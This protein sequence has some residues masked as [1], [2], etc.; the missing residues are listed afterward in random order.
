MKRLAQDSDEIA[1][2]LNFADRA[3]G[4]IFDHA[5]ALSFRLYQFPRDPDA[6]AVDAVGLVDEDRTDVSASAAAELARLPPCSPRKPLGLPA[7]LLC[8]RRLVVSE[9]E[10]VAVDVSSVA[11]LCAATLWKAETNRYAGAEQTLR[12]DCGAP[13]GG[14]LHAHHFRRHQGHGCVDDDLAPTY[15]PISARVDSCAANGTVT[16]TIS[17]MAAASALRRR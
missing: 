12:A 8:A 15:G 4:W 1:A 14:K 13:L 16:M 9:N 7:R 6:R 5:G 10:H 3:S 17:L 2:G 11:S